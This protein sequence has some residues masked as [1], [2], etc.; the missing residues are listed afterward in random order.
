MLHVSR[1]FEA[2]RRRERRRGGREG[3]G[4]ESR[5]KVLARSGKSEIECTDAGREDDE[6]FCERACSGEEGEQKRE[7]KHEGKVGRA[8]L[9]RERGKEERVFGVFRKLEH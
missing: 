2:G 3:E 7:R 9:I 8:V 6:G 5:M 4:E 1:S